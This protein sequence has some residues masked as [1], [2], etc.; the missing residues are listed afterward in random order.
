MEILQEG[1]YGCRWT[2]SGSLFGG[3]PLSLFEKSRCMPLGGATSANKA[4]CAGF[5][6]Q[7]FQA[8]R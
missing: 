6:K 4:N 3:S 1:K 2:L 5:R 8:A 7:N